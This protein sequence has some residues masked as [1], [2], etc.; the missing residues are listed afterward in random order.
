VTIAQGFCSLAIFL[1][2]QPEFLITTTVRLS[3]YLRLMWVFE[4]AGRPPL[5]RAGELSVCDALQAVAHA[6]RCCFAIRL[7][8]SRRNWAS[9]NAKG[10]KGKEHCRQER[11]AN[12]VSHVLPLSFAP[13][14]VLAR[15]LKALP[16]LLSRDMV[17]LL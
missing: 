17:P 11:A 7:L 1:V 5:V 10:T 16:G 4:K 3:G 9:L 2:A 13:A 6:A 12:Q 14:E 8:T 15:C